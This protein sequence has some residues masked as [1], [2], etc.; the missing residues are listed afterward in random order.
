MT[1]QDEGKRSK[2]LLP[3]ALSCILD[4][5]S[6]NQKQSISVCPLLRDN[7]AIIQN[8]EIEKRSFDQL[9]RLI[10]LC[11]VGGNVGDGVGKNG[12][13]IDGIS[14]I[15]QAC[16]SIQFCSVVTIYKYYEG[17]L[18]INPL[19]FLEMICYSVWPNSLTTTATI[20]MIK[21][22]S[23]L[24]MKRATME[25]TQSVENSQRQRQ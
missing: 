10:D 8:G 11:S 15:C 13:K 25:P 20:T 24:Q 9:G 17:S 23:G 7:W 1:N 12:T 16:Y 14:F 6:Q 3:I 21:G 2:Q 5:S 18:A 4:R 22:A 19:L